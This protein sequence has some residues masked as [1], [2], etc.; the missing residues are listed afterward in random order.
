MTEDDR[1]AEGMQVRREVL[2]D[3]HVDRATASATE[4][5]APFQAYITRAA[6]GEVWTRS[7]LD[8]RT[9]SLVTLALLAA[10][11]HE[12]ELALHTRAAVRNGVTPA[13]IVEV[14]MHTAVYAGAPAANAAM[15]VAHDTLVDLDAIDE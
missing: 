7:E 2:G 10:L 1:F 5:T 14:L 13:E 11:G 9:R 6:W 8:R 15:R 12:R 4:L 3:E